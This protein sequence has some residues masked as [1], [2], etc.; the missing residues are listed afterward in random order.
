M[1]YASATG[2]SWTNKQPLGGI[3]GPGEY[4]LVKLGSGGANGNP[5]PQANIDGDINMSASSGKLALV[6][7]SI[8]LTGSCPNGLN[9]AIVDF[10][11]YGSSASC[12]EGSTPAPAP[13]AVNAI[14]RKFN[15]AQDTTRMAPTLKQASPI[16]VAQPR[17]RNSAHGWQA[18]EP[19][20][21]GTNAPYDSTISID[22]SEP[23]D[24]TDN[25]YDI[26]CS[27]QVSTTTQQ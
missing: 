3:V 12:F 25:W 6:S 21:N 23:V 15:G 26:T 22:F 7:N 2:T 13:S 1:Q 8:N 9:P 27:R 5:L 20:V 18:A 14:F 16:L 24:V 19:L 11:G 10:V 17:S 4:F